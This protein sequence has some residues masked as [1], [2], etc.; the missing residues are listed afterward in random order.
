MAFTKD[1]WITQITAAFAK[2]PAQITAHTYRR[3]YTS[4]SNPVVLVCGDTNIEYVVKG[5]QNGRMIVNEQVVARLGLL[6]GAP[7]PHV[8]I[9]DV[10]QNLID[11]QPEMKHMP[12]GG[13]HGSQVIPNCSDREDCKH[14]DL[15]ENRERFSKI[16]VLYGWVSAGDRQFIYRIDPPNLVHSVDHGH[17]FP[18]GPNWN[19]AQLAGVPAAECDPNVTTSAKLTLDDLIKA[20]APLVGIQDTNI[21]EVVAIPPDDWPFSLD[22]RAAVAE[23]LSLRRDELIAG[24]AAKKAAAP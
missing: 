5:R 9:I 8:S 7:V 15:A 2:R 10:P 13:S 18:G 21:A 20:A 22:E 17:F 19:M 4:A 3:K 23:Y 16:A 24:L 12:S 11:A 1:Q 6:L 14:V